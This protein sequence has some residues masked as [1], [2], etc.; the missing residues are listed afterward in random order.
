MN[1]GYSTKRVCLLLVLLLIIS[2]LGYLFYQTYGDWE[3]A[4]AIRGKKWLAFLLVGISASFSTI[5]FQTLSHNHFI[6]PTILGFDALYVLIQTCLFF[7]FGASFVLHPQQQVW[8]FVLNVLLMV[9]MGTLLYSGLLRFAKKDIFILL[10]IGMI[11]GTLFSN[12]GTFLQVLMDPNE[13]DKLQ[14]RLFASFGN[15]NQQLLLYTAIGTLITIIWLWSQRHKLD[16]LLLGDDLAINLGVNV[17]VFR[18]QLL[19]AITLLVALSTALVGPILFLGFLVAN[20]TY[21]L[22]NR[23]VHRLLFAIGSLI[24]MTLLIVGQFLVEFIF[25]WNTTLSVV[26]EFIGGSYFIWLIWKQRKALG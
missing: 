16:V 2:T 15:I 26:I 5:T 17:A 7:L 13:Y 18:I 12:F 24:G 19:I 4:L 23:H 9:V 22:V 20:L 11:L 8:L 6:T 14:G 3:F 1:K 10:M 25:H 21:R